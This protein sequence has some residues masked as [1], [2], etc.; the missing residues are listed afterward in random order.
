M[1]GRDAYGRPVQKVENYS[2]QSVRKIDFSNVPEGARMSIFGEP[3][4]LTAL[5]KVNPELKLARSKK[6]ESYLF[7]PPVEE[8]LPF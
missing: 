7:L 1:E 8:E 2:L 5:G 4:E 3:E 6:G